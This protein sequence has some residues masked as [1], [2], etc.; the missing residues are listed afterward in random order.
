MIST[1]TTLSTYFPSSGPLSVLA[2]IVY[3]IVFAAGLH[4]SVYAFRGIRNSRKAVITLLILALFIFAP[5]GWMVASAL[6]AFLF[7]FT[8]KAAKLG[9]FLTGVATLLVSAVAAIAFLVVGDPSRLVFVIAGAVIL[10]F[11]AVGVKWGVPY[12][13]SK[14]KSAR[15]QRILAGRDH[16]DFPNKKALKW[17]LFKRQNRKCSLC[18]KPLDYDVDSRSGQVDPSSVIGD[19][20]HVIPRAAGAK[21]GGTSTFNNVTLTHPRCN[22][23]LKN[24]LNPKKPQDRRELNRRFNNDGLGNVRIPSDSAMAKQGRELTRFFERKPASR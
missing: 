6:G 9:W 23:T 5:E 7:S 18:A 22:R 15:Y 10:L 3:S 20:D 11:L 24:D 19:L 8:P 14:V 1:L 2:A 17:E 13:R 4:F 16:T 21:R 12:L